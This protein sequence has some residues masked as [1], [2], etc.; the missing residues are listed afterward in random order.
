MEPKVVNENDNPNKKFENKWLSDNE[1]G[2]Y[3][4][5]KDPLSS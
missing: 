3:V 2:I 5:K 1:Q 4:V